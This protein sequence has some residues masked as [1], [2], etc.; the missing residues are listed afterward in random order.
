ME[1]RRY[2]VG[3]TLGD[4]NGIGP[5]VI[6]KTLEDER[7]YKFCSVV[8]YGQKHVI[9]FYTKHLKIQNFNI[10]EVKDTTALNPKLPN[11]INC[12][13]EQTTVAPGEMTTEAATH[14]MTCLNEGI[15]DLIAGNI[16][17]LV[18]G[19][20]NKVF[21]ARFNPILKVKPNIFRKQQVTRTR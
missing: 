12:W 8:V 5:E 11:I 21:S 3:I 18:T 17:V 9:S 20:V 15:K 16:D 1:N 19:P 13:A 4:Y 2:K 10:Q 7:L 14:T 6:I